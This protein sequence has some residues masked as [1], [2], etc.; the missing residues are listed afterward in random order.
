MPSRNS[1]KSRQQIVVMTDHPS[2][3]TGISI[4]LVS[5]RVYLRRILQVPREV[6]CMPTVHHR[7]VYFRRSWR[8]SRCEGEISK[9]RTV[10]VDG[11]EEVL[12]DK[13]RPRPRAAF[14]KEQKKILGNIHNVFTKK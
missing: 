9:R 5:L 11:E 4:L 8:I 3:V 14:M 6:F 12:M 1:P 10:I 2:N 7:L 13:W